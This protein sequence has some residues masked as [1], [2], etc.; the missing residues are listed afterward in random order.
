MIHHHALTHIT[1][2]YT[3]KSINVRAMQGDGAGPTKTRLWDAYNLDGRSGARCA[4]GRHGLPQVAV[5]VTVAGLTASKNWRHVVC[6][7]QQVS[8]V[9]WGIGK[10][11]G[12]EQSSTRIINGNCGSSYKLLWA[13]LFWVRKI[14]RKVAPPLEFI[15]WSVST[16]ACLQIGISGAESVWLCS[17][18]F[19]PKYTN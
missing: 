5:V 15:F 18:G 6:D 9:V 3:N 4:Q 17:S 2:G 8:E 13:S 7:G 14:H 19:Y 10:R 16:L 1:T 11:R 12:E